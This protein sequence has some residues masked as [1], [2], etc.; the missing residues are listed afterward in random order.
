MTLTSTC[1]VIV[2]VLNVN[3]NPPYFLSPRVLVGNLVQGNNKET[4]IQISEG[5][6]KGTVFMQLLTQDPDG[7]DNATIIL[8]GCVPQPV[9]APSTQRHST[10]PPTRPIFEVDKRS[11]KCWTSVSFDRETEPAYACTVIAVDSEI[12]SGLT[13]T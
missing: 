5:L 11:G 6:E 13:S 12:P 8:E 9:D 3:D 10:Q 2:S 1:Q 7:S 4:V